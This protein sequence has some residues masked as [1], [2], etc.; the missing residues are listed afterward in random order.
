MILTLCYTSKAQKS[1]EYY[2]Y[3]KVFFSLIIIISMIYGIAIISKRMRFLQHNGD[4]CSLKL[5]EVLV[6]DYKNKIILVKHEENQYL[7]LLSAGANV[8]IDKI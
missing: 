7:L 4:K 1:M 8:L 3:I 5:Q 6:I 2:L